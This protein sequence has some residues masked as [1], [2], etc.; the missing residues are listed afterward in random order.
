[1]ARLTGTHLLIL[2][3]V[4]L[5]LAAR[6][7]AWWQDRE[8]LA[9]ADAAATGMTQAQARLQDE[10]LGIDLLPDGHYLS[11]EQIDGL[12][13][14]TGDRP[15]TFTYRRKPQGIYTVSA[16]GLDGRQHIS[17]QYLQGYAPF[18][19][20]NVM[21]PMYVIAQ[22][23]SYMFDHVQYRG[24]MDV[25][26]TSREGFLYPRGDC[27]DHAI[28]LADWLIEMGE[29]ARVVIGDYRGT[30]H[31]WVVLFKD[32]REYLLEAT[33][34]E[35]VSPSRTY[36]LA[37]LEPGYHPQVMF[38]RHLLWVNTGSRFNSRYSGKQWSLRSRLHR[39]PL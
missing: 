28:V 38:N 15:G 19:V 14:S 24:Q 13:R 11:H 3:I 21:L 18:T 37:L 34:K 1:M 10:R 16:Q 32:G 8:W 17:N 12:L 25:W 23:K 22:R 35:G 30:G 7:D 4:L 6:L 5:F 31:A 26:Q 27:E 33:R 29:D 36:P 9:A 39:R 2:A 20:S